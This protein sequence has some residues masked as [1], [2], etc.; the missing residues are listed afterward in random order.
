MVC[1]AM[2]E[3][4]ADARSLIEKLISFDSTSYRSNLNL[5][6]YIRDYLAEYKID[7]VLVFNDEKTK[8]NLYATIG[9]QDKAG[10]MLSGHT[11]VV[12]VKGQNWSSDPFI[13]E[14]KEGA[15]YGRGTADM[16][17]FIAIVLAYVPQMVE[18]KLKTPV[19]LA[20]S[21]DEEIGCVGVRRLLDMMQDMP[22]KPAMCVVGEPTSMQVV[23]AHK[24]K[25]AQLVR[26][27]GLEAHSS[28]PHIGVNAVDY[29]AELIVFIRKLAKDIKQDGPYEEGFEVTHTTI[30]TG[31]INGGVALNIVPNLCELKFEIRNIP[32]QDPEPIL[33]Q[34]IEYAKT[35]L[36][37]EMKAID[38][39]CG[40]EFEQLS[41]YPGMFTAP[42]ED[43]VNFV[44]TLTDVEGIKKVSFGTEGGLFTQQLGIP[45]VVCGPGNIEQAHK[46]DEF[47]HLKQIEQMEQF[48]LRLLTALS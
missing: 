29:A 39:N 24:G 17:S 33:Q 41:G 47:I 10:V 44:K 27:T 1:L 19:H 5:I 30:H 31:I 45:T 46:P 13:V 2:S 6:Y 21:Y 26:I 35:K 23:N 40:F 34:I 12:P 4:Q 38:G 8:A 42:N 48:M 43:V 20:F 18:A 9:P 25:L 32:K 22:I 16:K 15:L 37:P 11:D 7:S 14:E 36:E 3:Q 28:L